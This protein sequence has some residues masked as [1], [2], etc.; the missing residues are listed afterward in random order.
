MPARVRP[1]HPTAA[2]RR[3]GHQLRQARKAAGL[4]RPALAQAAGLPVGLIAKAQR[5]RRYGKAIEEQLLD[6]IA[7]A[8]KRRR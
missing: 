4:S 5:G 2:D 6:Q 1:H 3:F 7:R 8:A